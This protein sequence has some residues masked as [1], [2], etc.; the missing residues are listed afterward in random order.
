MRHHK[1]TC[2]GFSEHDQ[3]PLLCC[4]QAEVEGAR[5]A[6][7]RL[8]GGAARVQRVAS[9]AAEGRPHTAVVV[10]KIQPTHALY[11]RS[12]G[13]PNKNPLR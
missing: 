11:P 9:F 13:I 12:P 10:R 1:R 6:I 8:G 4:T 2:I 5:T 7:N 3:L